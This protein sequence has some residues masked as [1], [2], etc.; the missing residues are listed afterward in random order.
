M[1]V[2]LLGPD[3]PRF[4][5]TT[6]SDLMDISHRPVV[7]FSAEDSGIKKLPQVHALNCLKE[8]M[9]NSRFSAVVVQYLAGVLELAA[10][11]LS[12]KIWDIRNCGLMLLRAC[13]TRL[14][15]TNTNEDSS[16]GDRHHRKVG[17][18]NPFGIAVRLLE[19]AE[20]SASKSFNSQSTATEHVFAALDL[21]GHMHLNYTM[22]DEASSI[23][24]RQ[25]S[26]STWA[27]R[28]HAASLLATRLAGTSPPLAIKAL[29]G[30]S[31]LNK[32]E[33]EAHGILLC[34]R[35]IMR[36]ARGTT[37]ESEVRTSLEVLRTSISMEE[38]RGRSPYVR[39]TYLDVLNDAAALCLDHGCSFDALENAPSPASFQPHSEDNSIH[40]PYL[41]HRILLFR[42]YCYF[43][44]D[45]SSSAAAQQERSEYSLITDSIASLDS[46]YYLL[47]VIK[48]K[49]CE[50]LHRS[51]IVF[52]TTLINRG[53][54][55]LYCHPDILQLAFACLTSSLE[56][57][58][59]IP[60]DTLLQINGDLN[61]EQLPSTRELGNAV[62]ELEAVLLGLDLP[63]PTPPK[64]TQRRLQQW[65]YRLEFAAADS[66][67]FPTRLS[68]A[69]ALSTYYRASKGSHGPVVPEAVTLRLLVVLYDLLNDDDEEVRFEAIR[70]TRK[71]NPGRNPLTEDV[72]LCALA[73]R[74]LLLRE[75]QEGYLDTEV[76]GQVALMQ[77]I[78]VGQN[79]EDPTSTGLTSAPFQT[80]VAS[81]LAAIIKS[82][83]DL[84][85]EEKQN[86]YIDDLRELKVWSQILCRCGLPFQ[87][88]AQSERAIQWALEGLKQ[89]AHLLAI[90]Q[91]SRM[92]NS[93]TN[94][95]NVEEVHED[96]SLLHPLGST[97]D[98]EILVVFLQVINLARVILACGEA[99]AT[100]KDL[101][102]TLY[103][104][105]EDC[106]CA[107]VNVVLLKA[108]NLALAEH[109]P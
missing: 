51:I 71:L 22:A 84:F 68:A 64:A 49:H 99:T 18:G 85:A 57:L 3:D 69:R 94:R 37:A 65:L 45:V 47:G 10:N 17:E 63:S 4:F 23:I 70:A 40:W 20:D 105:R 80:T 55:E 15:S 61:L 53:Y 26:H 12:S 13:I 41:S 59:D 66:L 16:A 27:V 107:Q 104:V 74:E 101:L 48:E 96:T 78:K 90:E 38:M 67:D 75:I 79:V 28:D 11:C 62:I 88:R 19:S 44:C 31:G 1:M 58:T 81:R 97:Y 73:A 8:I 72:G 103:A 50:K 2:A 6:V 24:T 43:L 33:N 77:L 95:H 83:N 87:S 108:M 5:S 30:E 60:R 42:A 46:L 86:L 91:N 82:K 56:R 92:Q 93:A 98:H 7:N 34:C 102:K 14:G 32:P 29:L 9:T 109:C 35:Y 21:L 54:D 36:L 89:L 76:L 100:S 39:A 106:L 25:L 52:L